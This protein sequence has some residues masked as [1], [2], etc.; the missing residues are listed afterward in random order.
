M[1]TVSDAFMPSVGHVPVTVTGTQFNSLANEGELITIDSV[2]IT[3]VG[4][5]TGASFTVLGTARDG[6]TVAIRV[7]GPT[8]AQQ[9]TGLTRAD[10]VVGNYYR[11]TGVLTENVFNNVS[12]PQVKP[13]MRSDVVDRTVV[14]PPT[15]GV[16]FSEIHYDN[17]GTDAGEA[18]E[19]SAP[20]GMAANSNAK[21]IP[22]P[23][24]PKPHGVAVFS[25]SPR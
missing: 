20:A 21:A 17:A 22:P 7:H 2:Q 13:R 23:L 25:S 1:L 15:V 19:V 12:T 3:G 18:I 24:L 10:F 5:G 14:V 6:Q 9:N 11:V 4:G 16:R 8:T